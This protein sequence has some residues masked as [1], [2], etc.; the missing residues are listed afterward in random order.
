MKKSINIWIDIHLFQVSCWNYQKVYLLVF[1]SPLMLTVRIFCCYR[2][3]WN[4]LCING[5][6][7]V[8]SLYFHK[9]KAGP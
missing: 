9:Q 5:Q 7:S 6:S 1:L 4:T 2:L 8:I 3:V